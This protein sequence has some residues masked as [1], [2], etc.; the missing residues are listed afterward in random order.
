LSEADAVKIA[1][2]W[3]VPASGKEYVTRFL[4]TKTFVRALSGPSSNLVWI[5]RAL[6]PSMAAASAPVAQ[7]HVG[8]S[9]N[10][11]EV[12]L[13]G[14]DHCAAD[15]FSEV[16]LDFSPPKGPSKAIVMCA[17]RSGRSHF[18]GG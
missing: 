12:S 3:N 14:G 11:R 15:R 9:A 6:A 17:W 1:R 8:C 7:R 16:W 10:M 2:D 5:A 13:G 4:V 18:V